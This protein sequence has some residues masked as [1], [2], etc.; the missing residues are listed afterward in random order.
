MLI[1]PP[2]QRPEELA[3]G[4]SDRQV[5]DARETKPHEALLVELPV[6]V[7]VG[8]VPVLRVIVPLVCEA[9]GDAV[10]VV[11]P[12]LLDQ[13]VVELARPFACEELLDL[14]VADGELGAV[15]PLRVRRVDLS[16]S[17]GVARV[18]SVLGETNL[19][20]RGL[21]SEGRYRRFGVHGPLPMA[22]PCCTS[23]T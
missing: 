18:P 4:S 17:L 5:V 14:F 23:R 9:H 7:A 13:A 10:V 21:E 12:E 20:L 3:L 6:L 1:R 8:A 19:L 16:D 22:R 2:P 11:R 15:A